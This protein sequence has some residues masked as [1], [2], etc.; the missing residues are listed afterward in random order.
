MVRTDRKA[1]GLGVTKWP[2]RS[3]RLVGGVHLLARANVGCAAVSRASAQFD[4]RPP[5]GIQP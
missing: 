1:W 5:A 4:Y 2:R 3:Q